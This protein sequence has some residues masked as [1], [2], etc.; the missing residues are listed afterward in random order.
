LSHGV[1]QLRGRDEEPMDR[2][3]CLSY[4]VRINIYADL[5]I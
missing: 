5:R 3:E 2:Q 1:A 4:H